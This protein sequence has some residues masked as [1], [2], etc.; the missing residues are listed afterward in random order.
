MPISR[1]TAMLIQQGTEGLEC[2]ACGPNGQ[3]KYAGWLNLRQ[4]SDGRPL[5]LL[6]SGYVFGRPEEAIA[7]MSH[8]VRD[9]IR[10]GDLTL[11]DTPTRA[12][13]VPFNLTPHTN[14]NALSIVPVGTLNYVAR[15]EDWQGVTKAVFVPPGCSVDTSHPAFAWLADRGPRF[16][17]KPVKIR[18]VLSSGLMVR[19][20]DDTPLGE[21]WTDVLGITLVESESE[22]T[23]HDA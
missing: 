11:M 20:P 17:V 9:V 16:T 3:G 10:K 22:E 8:V 7:E 1:I 19:V 13:V 5:A 18:G 23:T 15:T 6:S 4:G 12:V 14:A 21:D 2:M